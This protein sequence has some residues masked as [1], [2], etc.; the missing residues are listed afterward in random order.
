MIMMMIIILRA[1][2]TTMITTTTTT[3]HHD[4]DHH[5]HDHHD[6]GGPRDVL[7][8]LFVPHGH[9]SSSM[10]DDALETSRQGIRA[11]KLSLV[12]LGLTALL[13]I[14]VVIISGSV[15][16]LADT[17]HNLSDA[18]TAVPLW[19]AFVIGRRP[20]SRRYTYGFGRLEDV[21]G[22]FIV[23]MIAISALLAGVESIRRLL[24]PAAGDEPELGGGRRADRVRRQR[25][26]GRSTA[27]ASDDGSALPP[28]SLTACTP[29]PTGSPRSRWCSA[30]SASGSASRWPIRSWGC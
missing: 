29:A 26:R 20:P 28:W 1:G 7:R 22:L 8:G 2:T 11:V 9:D 4:H 3:D 14:A 17:V 12:I 16:L 21:A 30:P 24:D 19:I 15:A 6:R 10:I 18:L 25:A 27:S 13:Q 5:D 23:V